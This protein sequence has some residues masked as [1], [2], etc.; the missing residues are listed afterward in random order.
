MNLDHDFFQV[1]KLSEDQKKVLHQKWN[2]FFPPNSGEDQKKGFH[3]KW[4]SIFPQIQVKTKKRLHAYTHMHTRVKLLEG[5]QMKTILKLL[6]EIQSNYWE[7][8][9]PPILRASAPLITII[10][11]HCNHQHLRV[12]CGQL[13]VITEFTHNNSTRKSKHI[14]DHFN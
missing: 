13:T 9:Y 5:M 2:S 8:I 6:G 4:N 10:Q 1:S 11:K 12:Y 14:T 7:G 3:Q